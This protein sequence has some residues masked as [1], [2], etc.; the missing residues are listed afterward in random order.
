M[1]LSDGSPRR[2]QFGVSPARAYRAW[3][4]LATLLAMLATAAPGALAAKGRHEAHA[5]CKGRSEHH[6]CAAHKKKAAEKH[7]AGAKAK[8]SAS[9]EASSDD[10]TN[11]TATKP[12][13]E[14]CV[15]VE[16]VGSGTEGE[17]GESGCSSVPPV[18]ARN[19][20][21]TSE[22]SEAP[23]AQNP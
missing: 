6:R 16:P 20:S 9:Q 15:L 17:A 2:R 12:G 5:G 1:R 7:G 18:A 21:Q 14:R 13:E 8:S 23:I 11:G 4:V 19:E 10:P 3:T 22:G